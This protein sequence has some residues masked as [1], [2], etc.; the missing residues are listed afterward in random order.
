MNFIAKKFL[1]G[2]SIVLTTFAP[3]NAAQAQETATP[4]ELA[5]VAQS[6][7]PMVDADP[8]LWVV[9]DKDTTIYL[10]GTVHILKPNLTWFDE[11]VKTAFDSSDRLVLELVEPPQAESQ[12]AFMAL[13]MDKTGK[14]LRTKMTEADRTAYEAALT[15]LGMPPAAL[16]PFDP[17]AAAVSLQLISV[18]KQ[19]FDPKSGAESVLTSAAKVA[20]KPIVGVE[21]LGYQLGIFDKLPEEQQLRFLASSVKEMDNS[22][23]MMTALIDSWAKPE[24]EVL[25]T[26]MNEGINDPALYYSLL[27]K[28]NANWAKWINAQMTKP[29]TTFMAVGAGHLSGVTS[30]PAM[31]KAYGRTVERVAY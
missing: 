15:K 29:G 31:L 16:D 18:M 30:V 22:Q 17:W 14:G 8:A 7:A 13:A 21:T 27:T 25:A 6:A 20:N 3:S 26:L 2:A 10:F 11:G 5:A 4:T 24:P 28:R 12:A 1:I 19:G 23:A 9:K